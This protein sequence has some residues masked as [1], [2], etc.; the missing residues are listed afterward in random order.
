MEYRNL[1]NEEISIIVALSIVYNCE[2]ARR[3]FFDR[4]GKDA[5]PARTLRHWKGRFLET[6]SILPK[7]RIGDH[8]AR[9]IPEEKRDDIIAAFADFPTT[10]QRRVSQQVGV[11]VS[12][13]NKVLKEEGVKPF[14]FTRVQQLQNDD[15]PKRLEFCE[16]LLKNC[17]NNQNFI[18]NLVFSDEACFHL[19]G[20]VN[21]HNTFIYNR[22]NPHAT[23]EKPMKS[24]A[25]V[26]WA[27]VSPKIGIHFRI[28]RSTIN[29]ENYKDIL[30]S[31]VIP[32]FKKRRNRDL[33]Y[34]HDGAPSHFSRQV[35]DVLDKE[36]PHR[37]I[38]RGS[39]FPWPPRSPDLSVLDFWLWGDIR[40]K[41]YQKHVPQNLDELANKLTNLLENIET[42]IIERSFGS[43]LRR[44]HLCVEQSGS[45]FEHLL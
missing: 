41:L 19:N 13:V 14:K 11:S 15:K 1:N 30:T 21:S 9:R 3:Q 22:Q 4:F 2:E 20:N 38:G 28:L 17:E 44:C 23:V 18:S 40:H 35:R 24:A 25:I 33:I 32:I 12:S 43:F 37:W 5:P 7:P 36:I 6:L 16:K 26:C 42:D 29:G 34:Q 10:S 8:S 45:H 27:M 39:S 31:T